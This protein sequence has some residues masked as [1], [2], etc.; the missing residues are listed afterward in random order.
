MNLINVVFSVIAGII[1]FL[2]FLYSFRFYKNIKN[3]ERYA[4][5]MLFTR[6]EAINAFKF[7]ALCGFFH[8]ISMI[9][10]AIGLQ[11]QDPIISK[12]SKT[13]CIMLMIGFFYFFL[14]LEK[15]TKKSRWKEK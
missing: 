7:L 3:D 13:G 11:L 14:T 5:A 4:L 10:S 15:V 9:V 8:G 12:L 2:A 1:A 6:K